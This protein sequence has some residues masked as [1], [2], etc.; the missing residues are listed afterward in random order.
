MMK[1]TL[2]LALVAAGVILAGSSSARAEYYIVQDRATKA[3]TILD[4]RP[5]SPDTM[6]V[7]GAD[8]SFQTRAEAEIGMRA[9]PACQS[10]TAPRSSGGK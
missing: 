4:Q 9:E 2:S 8:R 7:G 3:C 10:S 6:T 1:C 5:A